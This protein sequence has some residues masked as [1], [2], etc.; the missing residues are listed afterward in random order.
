[1]K[2]SIITAC[3]NSENSIVKTINSVNKQTYKNIEHVFI[4][5]SSKDN[6]LNL[7]E[8]F[9]KRKKVVISKKDSGVYHAMNKGLKISKGEIIFIL[10]SDDIFFSNNI[11]ENIVNIF[12]KNNKISIVYGNIIIKKN[13]SIY[14]KWISGNYKDYTFLNGWTPPHPGFVVKKKVY[15]KYGCFNL[16]YKFA[17]DLEIMYRLLHQKNLNYY[18]YDKF[19]VEMKH[20]GI[21]SKNF[22]NRIFQNIENIDIFKSDKN[23]NIFKFFYRKFFHRIKQFYD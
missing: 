3:Y 18:Y 5:G 21:S 14:R 11:V 7:V 22:K 20:G 15:N 23:F 10:N 17:A 12:K 2:V 19:I 16:S 1:M 13:K 8:V 4:D 9:S 6:T